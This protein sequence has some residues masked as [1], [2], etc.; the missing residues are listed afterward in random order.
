MDLN[1]LYAGDPRAAAFYEK[2][3]MDIDD[4]DDWPATYNPARQLDQLLRCPIC[5]ELFTTPMM[6]EGC[7]HVHCSRCIRDRITQLNTSCPMCERECK[8]KNL[9]PARCVDDIVVA[10]KLARPMLLKLALD[11]ERPPLPPPASPSRRE[12]VQKRECVQ[13]GG[14][15][16]HSA[17]SDESTSSSPHPSMRRRGQRRRRRSARLSES[18]F[19]AGDDSNEDNGAAVSDDDPSPTRKRAR[20]TRND[21]R[22][23]C[24]V[25]S[26]RVAAVKLEEHVNQCLDAQQSA[27]AIITAAAAAPKSA[28]VPIDPPCALV[29]SGVRLPRVHYHVLKDAQV[30]DLLA[31][32]QLPTTG[33]RAKLLDRH[34]AWV[35]LWNANM[36][37]HEDRRQSAAALRRQLVAEER[38]RSA[39][40]S[41]AADVGGGS[42]RKRGT[43]TAVASSSS[44]EGAIAALVAAAGATMKSR[45]G[46]ASSSGGNITAAH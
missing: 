29:A 8:E 33:P 21:D 30:R 25:C 36:D 22:T 17:D 13:V 45:T 37:A 11:A 35:Q 18:D 7:W 34:R 19:D 43:T 4:P 6:V 44:S 5:H 38:A 27:P 3:L 14:S 39:K 31:T 16:M 2:N 15:G 46:T 20:T 41:E 42:S 1:A 10:F 40:P 23:E 26:N 12:R 9:I 28:A 24:P 32:Y